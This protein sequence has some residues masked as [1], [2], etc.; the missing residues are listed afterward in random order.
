MTSFCSVGI[1]VEWPSVRLVRADIAI[2]GYLE[3]PFVSSSPLARGQRRA[4]NKRRFKVAANCYI[5][6]DKP[7]GW[8]FDLDTDGT[9]TGHQKPMSIRNF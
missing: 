4:R 3:T 7:D 8:P 5:R 6:P 9:K 1:E 2:G